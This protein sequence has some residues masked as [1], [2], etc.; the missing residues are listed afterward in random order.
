[1]A[2]QHHFSI[3]PDR[4]GKKKGIIAFQ[5]SFN[6]FFVSGDMDGINNLTYGLAN[7][8]RFKVEGL[9]M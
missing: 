3:L 7:S 2:D 8:N 5:K 1:M 9:S 6:S 4:N